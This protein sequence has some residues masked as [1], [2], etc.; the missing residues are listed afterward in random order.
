MH[1][2]PWQ[3]MG[4]EEQDGYL[5]DAASHRIKH[6]TIAKV[7]IKLVTAMTLPY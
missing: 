6:Y 7:F 1:H 5:F 2:L 4:S 3:F